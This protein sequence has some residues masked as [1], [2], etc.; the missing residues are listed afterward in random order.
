MLRLSVTQL[1]N[2]KHCPA[3][4][5]VVSNGDRLK[6]MQAA[7][8]LSN[9]NVVGDS[10]MKDDFVFQHLETEDD[11]AQHLEIMRTVFGQNSRIDLLVKKWLDHH[12]TMKL[13]DFFV[14][15]HHG[16]IVACLN[17]I[18]AEWSLGG[19]LLKVAELGCVATL[20]EYR[21][22][23]LQRRLMTEYYRQLSEQRY[24]L[25]AIEG[26]PYY[27]RQFGYEYALPLEE[28]TRIK[29]DAIPDYQTA[30]N[31]RRFTSND[32]RRAMHL[33]AQTQEKFY[34]HSVRDEGVWKMQQQT[35]IMSEY[36]FEGYSV[37]ENGQMIAHFRING[38]PETRELFLREITDT[39][40]PTAQ[41]ILTFLKDVGKQRGLD[42]LV[43]RISA[44]ETLAKQ[45]MATG[46]A[47]QKPPTHGRC[48]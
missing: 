15:K 47:E 40:Q 45:M 12:P 2:K 21:H 11:I 6:C 31:V 41:S 24:N 38:N 4:S 25:S 23:G 43:A 28:E 16:K 3:C 10:F 35:S 30:H 20:P 46:E 19:I 17:L 7:S 33:L 27:Y 42:T 34:V 44:H 14:I 26:I 36:E 37:E 1:F 39:D 29:I 5:N 13:T 9:Q 18:P 22:Q 8:S 32:V 48:K